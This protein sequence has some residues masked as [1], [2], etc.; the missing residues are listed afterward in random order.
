MQAATMRAFG[1]ID[2]LQF[3][4]LP[5]LKPRPGHVIVRVSAVG[6]NYYDILLR[7]GA[8]SR[9]IALPHVIGSDVVGEI[10]AL[11]ADVS[12]WSDGDKVIVAPGFPHDPKEWG[13]SPEN[14]A[15]SY[16]PTGTFGWGGYAQEMEVAARWLVRDDTGL[17]PEELATI[18][19]VLV[20]AVHAVKTLGQVGPGSKVL[21]QAGASGTGSMAIQVAKA[22]GAQVVAT[23]STVEKA[24]LA[25]R[26]GAD[27][28]IRYGSTNVAAAVR[29]WTAGAGVDVVIDPVGGS[30]MS[31]NVECLK[32]RG[33]IVNLGLSGGVEAK[34]SN[35]YGFFRNERRIVGAWMG[36]M[37]E[38]AFGLDLVKQGKVR[39]VLHKTLPL[40]QAREAHRLIAAHEVMGK[41]ALLPWAA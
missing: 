21:V 40:K 27:E 28:V 6:T 3:E 22:L 32:P 14:E 31:A 30:A 8:V 19:L 16:Y 23:T 10:V 20:T 13:I 7:T 9:E 41:L 18:P 36:S 25:H 29:N 33:T 26:L 2:V 37:T 39:P 4:N 1:D 12:G 17:A 24:A 11:G 38:L 35:L 34:I 15:P 5:P